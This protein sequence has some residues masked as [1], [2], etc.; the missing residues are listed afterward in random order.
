MLDALRTHLMAPEVYGAFVRGFTAEWN[1]E[2]DAR[3]AEQAGKRDELTRLTGRIGKLVDAVA[4]NGS[5]AALQQVLVKA[6][7][8]EAALE[9]KS[10]A[11]EAA[12]P[13]LMPTLADFYRVRI[14]GLRAV[15][16]GDDAGEVRERIRALVE[17]IRLIP[18]PA[19]PSSPL[20]IEVTGALAALLALGSGSDRRGSEASGFGR[21]K[22]RRIV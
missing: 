7:A 19:D 2:R 16:G 4:E 14:E 6:E 12:A 18:C 5:A 22:A 9:V 13:R 8:C 10:A 20:T 1:K 3:H 11:A 17:E 21:K 15:L